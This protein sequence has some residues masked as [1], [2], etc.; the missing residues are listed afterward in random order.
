MGFGSTCTK[1]HIHNF[2]NSC[3]GSTS[4]T[5]M[6]LLKS[7]LFCCNKK[8]RLQ[9]TDQTALTT[10][11]LA[12]LQRAGHRSHC[13]LGCKVCN[14]SSLENANI[15]DHRTAAAR[16]A[17]RQGSGEPRDVYVS[18]TKPSV[19]EEDACT[20]TNT[21]TVHC[22]GR[23]NKDSWALRKK[24]EEGWGPHGQKKTV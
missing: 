13:W 14:C 22:K 4:K 17:V 7:I 19:W 2:I 5:K 12:R 15:Y 23:L 18:C 20:H 9:F 24:K 1:N 6:T 8:S 21:L 3:W 10:M 16:A 11:P